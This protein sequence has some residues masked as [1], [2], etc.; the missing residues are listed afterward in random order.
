MN[1]YRPFLVA[2]RPASLRII[3][4]A[5]L[6]AFEK[7]IGI[8]THA[9]VSSNVKSFIREF[10]SSA[11]FYEGR[12]DDP[13]REERFVDPETGELTDVGQTIADRTIRMCDSGAFLKGGSKFDNYV[14]LFKTYAEMDADYGIIM[15]SLNDPEE[16]LATARDAIEAYEQ[17]EYPFELVGVTQGRTPEEYLECYTA[18]RDLGYDHI[19]VG[20]LLQKHGDR[21]G[22]FAHVDDEEFVRQVLRTLRRVYPDDWLFVLGCHHPRRQAMFEE[23]NVF[24]SDYKGW[25]YNYKKRGDSDTIDARKWRYQQVRSFLQQ[26]ILENSFQQADGRLLVLA[27]SNNKREDPQLLSAIERYDGAYY[28]TLAKHRPDTG[29][30]EILIFSA[31]YGLIPEKYQIP[32]YDKRLEANPPAEFIDDVELGIKNHLRYREYEQIFVVA[33]KNYRDFL[34]E[35]LVEYSDETE[36][37]RVDGRLGTQLQQLKRWLQG[38]GSVGVS[39][40]S[41]DASLE[42]YPQAK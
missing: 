28:R 11:T 31:K 14:N 34:I 27:C 9:N 6:E 35:P 16:T 41:S 36:V 23:F 24:G 40:S 2:D 10:P 29:G 17:Q 19:A 5:D 1:E 4:G 3:R 25:I 15:D 21:S 20:G 30:P 33:G 22:A 26:N 8:M 32:A 38:E 42:D 13:V 12:N 37:R 7:S 18:L 39:V